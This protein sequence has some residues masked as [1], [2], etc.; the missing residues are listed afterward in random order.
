MNTQKDPQTGNVENNISE[1]IGANFI[2]KKQVKA[3]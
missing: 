3:V 2:G 1:I